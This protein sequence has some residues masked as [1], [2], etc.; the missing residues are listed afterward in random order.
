MHYSQW[1][2]FEVGL[3]G[4]VPQESP[5]A[6]RFFSGSS[7]PEGLGRVELVGD[8]SRRNP[9][10][11]CLNPPASTAPLVSWAPRTHLSLAGV[12]RTRGSFSTTA[13][14][15]RVSSSAAT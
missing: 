9:D 12:I 13:G 2:S 6:S 4:F 5:E 10:Q 14:R 15:G 3:V 1:E 7:S 8:R 11:G